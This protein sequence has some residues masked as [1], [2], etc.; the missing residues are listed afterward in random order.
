MVATHRF[1]K[2]LGYMYVL[3]IANHAIGFVVSIYVA[4]QLGSEGFGTIAFATAI[5]S[6]FLI[7]TDFGVIVQGIKRISYDLNDTINVTSV[8]TTIRIVLSILSCCILLF[9]TIFLWR[10]FPIGKRILIVLMAISLIPNIYD[11]TWVFMGHERMENR[12]FTY[13]VRYLSN[14]LIIFIALPYHKTIITVGIA[15][16]VSTIIMALFSVVSYLSRFTHIRFEKSITNI[17]TFLKDSIFVGWGQIMT[18]IYY[19]FGTIILSFVKG[20]TI[21]GWYNAGWRVFMILVNVAGIYGMTYL[22]A[23]VNRYASN[24]GVETFVQKSFKLLISLTLPVTAICYMLAPKIIILLFGNEYSNAVNPFRILL[25]SSMIIFVSVVF[26]YTLLG[27]NRQ[28]DL[29][30]Y[31]TVAAFINLLLNLLLIPKYSMNGAAFSNCVSELIVLLCVYVNFRQHT[32]IQLLHILVKPATAAGI[33][34][35][36]L[37]CLSTINPILLLTSSLLLYILV[38]YLIGGITWSDVVFFKKL[39]F[40]K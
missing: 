5:L 27:L 8:V 10:H 29:A 4:R 24:T 9:L 26:S 14:A 30:I 23:F 19:N 31:S 13:F 32:K 6:Y 34:C 36:F 28:K 21:V 3:E 16:L 25:C 7:I 2:N 20:D 40:R 17:T 39:L 11:L 38:L 37:Y 15:Y 35:I 22:P 12:A 18:R 1:I 33:M